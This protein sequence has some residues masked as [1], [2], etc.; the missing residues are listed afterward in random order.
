MISSAI[1]FVFPFQELFGEYYIDGGVTYN[2]NIY[3]AITRCLD[4]TG[5]IESQVTVD[6]LQCSSHTLSENKDDLKTSDVIFRVLK[7]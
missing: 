3:T 4:V 7:I 5:G 6:M 2:N 1:P